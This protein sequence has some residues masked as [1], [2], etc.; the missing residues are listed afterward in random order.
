MFS[1]NCAVTGSG[2]QA[3]DVTR[4]KPGPGESE[5]SEALSVD[6]DTREGPGLAWPT[7]Q[8][9]RDQMTGAGQS[10]TPCT[11]GMYTCTQSVQHYALDARIK[12]T[13]LNFKC[14]LQCSFSVEYSDLVQRFGIILR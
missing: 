1:I 10:C 12:N 3:G 9:L 2:Q 13:V 14:I 5:A 4:V 6:C 8:G 7:C 11:H